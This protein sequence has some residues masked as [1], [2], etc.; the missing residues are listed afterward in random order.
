MNI[1][2]V[3]HDLEEEM[4]SAGVE[5]FRKQSREAIAKGAESTSLH[6]ILLMKQTVIAL[7]RAI[8]KFTSNNTPGKYSAIAPLIAMLDTDV[9]SFLALRSLMDGIS[10]SQKL[11]NL[12]HRIAQAFSDQVRFNIWNTAD[13][14]YFK[15]LV[16]RVGKR[17][18]SRHYRRY[19]LIRH[20]KWKLDKNETKNVWTKLEEMHVG[21]KMIDLI[22]EST[23]LIQLKRVQSRGKRYS[24]YVVV[25]TAKTMDLITE[26]NVKGELDV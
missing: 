10:S 11:T 16:D 15:K 4:V 22:I 26:I 20:C 18:A 17:S 24:S 23:G 5:K 2:E 8:E 14:E 19:G 13:K 12:A 1:F 6:G 25:P 7:E 9:A 21:L 3:Q